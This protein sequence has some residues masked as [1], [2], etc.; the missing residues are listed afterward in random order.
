MTPGTQLPV[1]AGFGLTLSQ[2]AV[3]LLR[4][5]NEDP[6]CDITRL[7]LMVFVLVTAVEGPPREAL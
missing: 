1:F 4:L 6:K 7:I 3:K 2:Q 5:V